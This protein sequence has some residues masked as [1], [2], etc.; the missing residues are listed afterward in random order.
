MT[1][2]INR[3]IL[4]IFTSV[5]IFTES[6]FSRLFWRDLVENRYHGSSDS[7]HWTYSPIG[8]VSLWCSEWD[9]YP[10]EVFVTQIW[11][12][13]PSVLRRQNSGSLSGY[14][15]AFFWVCLGQVR[16]LTTTM[17]CLAL[18]PLHLERPRSMRTLSLWFLILFWDSLRDLIKL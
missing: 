15:P 18:K 14:W 2:C 5:V 12:L 1:C 6:N 16:S 11:L 10:F 3:S 4:W 7:A 8:I 17:G 13:L 9:L